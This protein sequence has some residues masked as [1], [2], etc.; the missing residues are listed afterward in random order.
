M[1]QLAKHHFETE[2]TGVC[3]T[4]RADYVKQLGADRVIDYKSK[5]YLKS[6]STYDFVIDIL[7]KSSFS[8]YKRLLKP[9]GIVLFLS[10]KT[11][12]LLQMLWMS[13]FSRQKAKC[14]LANPTINNLNFIKQIIEEGKY[15]SIIDKCFTFNQMAKAQAYIENKKN[16]GSVVIQIH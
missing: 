13:L 1:V 14:V 10:F 6:D 16:K 12:Q 2:V 9:E 4:N 15:K 7:G 8:S 11:K 3:S 5:D